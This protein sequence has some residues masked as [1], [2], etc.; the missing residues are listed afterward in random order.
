MEEYKVLEV[1]VLPKLQNA[2]K[3]KE[4][5]QKACWQVQPIMRKRSWRVPV[6]AEFL[7]RSPNL[8]GLNHN[9]GEKIEIR[10]RETKDGPFFPYEHA[11]GT[12][13]H[14][15]VHIVQGPHN[16]KFYALLDELWGECEGLMDRDVGGSGSGFDAT[17][18]KLSI[19]SHNPSSAREG[20]LKALEALENRSKKQQLMGGG[21]R[22]LGGRPPPVDRTPAQMSA[23]AALRRQ[24]DD[25]WCHSSQLAKGESQSNLGVNSVV[26]NAT[27][28][29]VTLAQSSP[30]SPT[31]RKREATVDAS[32]SKKEN[33]PPPPKRHS[34]GAPCWR[35]PVC[36]LENAASLASCDVC[37]TPR[38]SATTSNGRRNFCKL[39]IMGRRDTCGCGSCQEG[40]SGSEL[41][42]RLC[43]T[44]TFMSSVAR[45]VDCCT[46]CGSNFPSAKASPVGSNDVVI[47]D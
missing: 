38:D 42:F 12:L 7:P 39:A 10:L 46:M 35:C 1:T 9:S 25:E 22:K 36:T 43:T 28:G 17:G 45:T 21:G 3:A 30:T 41:S 18:S 26:A 37:A 11:L 20:R 8:L 44:C 31:S 47:L 5:L 34:Q 15:L 6:V 2:D 33:V 23:E 19:S 40:G 13:L 4:I 24:R 29:S 27:A 16:A 14:E 32:S